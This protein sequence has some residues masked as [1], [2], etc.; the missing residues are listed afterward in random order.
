MAARTTPE[1]LPDLASEQPSVSVVIPCLDEAESVAHCVRGATDALASA[2]MQ[3]EVIVVD[4]GSSDG[5]GTLAAEAG[6]KVVSEPRRGYGSAYLAGFA[7]ARGRYILMADA[8]GS[9]ELSDA[10]RFL[11]SLRDGADLVIGSRLRGH[12]DDGAMPWLHRRVGNPLLTGALNL[13][14]GTHVSDAHCGMRAF[15]R[16]LLERLRLQATG[17]E[18]ASELLIR[19]S[20]LGLDIRELPIDYRPRVGESKLASWPDGWRHLRLLLVHSP[21]WL[22]L[23]PGVA[24]LVLGVLAGALALVGEPGASAGLPLMLLAALL[25]IVGSQLVQFGA[26]ARSYAVWQLGERDPFFDRVRRRLSLEAVLAAGLAVALGGLALLAVALVRWWER[27]FGRFPDEQLAVGG[28]AL[29]VIG[30]QIVFTGFLL[31]VLGL[32]RRR[33]QTRPSDDP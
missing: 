31:S 5:S 33:S 3:G 30:T 25:A 29:V 9:Y 11:A 2:G 16:E 18:F 10:P 19:S 8:D 24:L 12:I 6:A 7:A 26:F 22:F 20:K 23:I 17:M 21:T 15:R 28:L 1:A 32:R 13:F 27:G 4:N 14:F